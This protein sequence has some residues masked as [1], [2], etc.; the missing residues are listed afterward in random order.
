MSRSSRPRPAIPTA[1]HSPLRDQ[2][3]PL[4]EPAEQALERLVRARCDPDQLRLLV[5]NARQVQQVDR[6]TVRRL[7]KKSA[8]V[9][10]L[11]EDLAG[12]PAG[13]WVSPPLGPG[14][15]LWVRLDVDLNELRHGLEA[16]LAGTRKKHFGLDAA[17]AQLCAYVREASG[18]FHDAEVADLLGYA[19][20]ENIRKFRRDHASLVDGFGRH[21]AAGPPKPPS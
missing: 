1:R 11:I 15:S 10:A 18:R 9:T 5:N 6:N 7:I 17:I 21:H 12:T 13:L 19:D 16:W 2:L 20:A 8:D 14:P 4:S 3:D